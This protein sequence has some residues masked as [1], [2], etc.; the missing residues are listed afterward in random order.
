[1]ERVQR[2][3][4]L[5]I[6]DLSRQELLALLERAG[7]LEAGE[8]RGRP[9]A[10]K[11]L[12]MIFRKSSTRTRVSFEVGMLQ[13]GGHAVFLAE[14][15]TQMGRGE[16]TAD[17]ARVLSRYVDAIVIR[18]FSHEEVLEMARYASVPVING[19]TDLHHPTQILADVRTIQQEFGPELEGVRVAWIGDGNNMANSWIDAAARLGFELRLACPEGYDPDE[20]VLQRGRREGRVLLVRDPREAAEGA[21][22]VTTDVWTSMGQEAEMEAR[23]RAFQGYLV[24][25]ALMERA[26]PDAIFLH[27]LPAHRG[28]EVTAEVIDGPASRVFR[29]AENRLHVQKALLLELL[30]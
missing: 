21:R 18:T 14:R 30:E 12:A 1:L 26:R 22:V 23:A 7:R 5:E 24:D 13:L 27:C 6:S 29:E 15:D 17:T 16:N 10:G 28:E 8:E 3:D 19:L 11:T 20:T 2:R 25:T 4:F 9:L